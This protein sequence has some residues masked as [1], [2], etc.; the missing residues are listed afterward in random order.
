MA[1][2]QIGMIQSRI[3]TKYCLAQQQIRLPH[4]APGVQ[5]CVCARVP[6]QSG[7]QRRQTPGK[8][9]CNLTSRL[10]FCS[11]PLFPSFCPLPFSFSSLFAE[12][13]T[14]QQQQWQQHFLVVSV[15]GSSQCD[16]CSSSVLCAVLLFLAGS[17]LT[18]TH[19][20]TTSSH[21]RSLSALSLP[22]CLSLFLLLSEYGP[23]GA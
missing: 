10:V 15:G 17:R 7:A 23:P 9:R 14:E 16:W 13:L 4:N 5:L 19:S 18:H 21:T 8:A 20:G 3:K 22:I 2:T 1:I 6:L 11:L 12:E